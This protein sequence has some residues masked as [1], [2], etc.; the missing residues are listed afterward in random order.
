M[1]LWMLLL[2]GQEGEMS[3]H[4]GRYKGIL[5]GAKED[6]ELVSHILLEG[7]GIQV[8]QYSKI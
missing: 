8:N 5:E 6:K 3:G 1:L 2:K 4:S 7:S